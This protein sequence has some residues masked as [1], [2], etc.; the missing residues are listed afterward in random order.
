MK[1]YSHA[2]MHLPVHVPS[3]KVTLSKAVDK[4]TYPGIEM[5]E[6]ERGVECKSGEHEFTIPYVN[7][8]ILVHEKPAII[9]KGE[10]KKK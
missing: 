7:F 9:E 1:K 6:G 10:A 8:A 3:L 4:K 5:W 2:I